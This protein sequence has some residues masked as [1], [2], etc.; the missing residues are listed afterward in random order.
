MKKRWRLGVSAVILVF[1]FF[2]HALHSEVVI[3]EALFDP[4]G[5]DT[6]LEYI[7]IENTGNAPKELTGWDLYP[8]GVGYYTF[9]AFSLEPKSVVTI[10]LRAPG[11]N[12]VKNLYHSSTTK[13]MGNTSGSIALFSS[14]EH[15]SETIVDF[16]EYGG[17][18]ETWEPAAVSA[19]LWKTGDF[20][21]LEGI[22]EGEKIR[23]T[24]E[25]HD[26]SAWSFDGSEDGVSGGENSE[27]LSENE[28]EDLGEEDTITSSNSG[29]GVPYIPPELL[30]SIKAYAGLD[31][32]AVAGASVSF[33][34]KAFGWKNEPL[35]S[36]TLRFLWNFGDGVLT[37]GRN[38]RHTYAYPGIYS[39]V[40]EVISGGESVRDDLVVRAGENPVVISEL[41]PGENGWIE[42]HNS[43]ARDIDIS[44]WILK[45]EQNKEFVFPENSHLAPRSRPVFSKETSGI[46]FSSLNPRAALSYPNGRVA[47]EFVFDGGIPSG[48]SVTALG[49]ASPTP[50]AEN[51]SQNAPVAIKQSAPAKISVKTESPS[52]PPSEP[53]S[54]LPVDDVLLAETSRVPVDDPSE[55]SGGQEKNLA[56]AQLGARTD[57]LWLGSSIAGGLVLGSAVAF[58]RRRFVKKDNDRTHNANL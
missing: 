10:H 58:A 13:N 11:T 41:A 27:D 1:P 43:S 34:G 32:N 12:D 4:E 55:S 35:E 18:G 20:V 52:A 45:G 42:L 23:R 6:G 50:G 16:V 57:Y 39:V 46:I 15:S 44:G 28:E 54:P 14:T 19:G 56:L 22:L 9:P 49:F 33:S 25:A 26:A 40:L 7:V 21:S 17:E 30:P 31:K 3:R 37:D 36:S 29:G 38:A 2:A 8:D 5:T 24:T 53:P 47:R 51:Q 48:Q